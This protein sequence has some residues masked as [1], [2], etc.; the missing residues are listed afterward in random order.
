VTGH[1]LDDREVEIRVQVGSR[2]FTSPYRLYQ[3]WGPSNGY[4]GSFLGSKAAEAWM[5]PLTPNYCRGQENVYLYIHPPVR[6]H[7]KV[8]TLPFSNLWYNSMWC[9]NVT[10]RL[11]ISPAISLLSY[12]ASWLKYWHFWLVFERFPIQV[13]AGTP[14]VLTA[15]S[16]FTDLGQY[17]FLRRPNLLLIDYPATRRSTLWNINSAVN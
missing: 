13:S 10:T 4:W 2:I 8:T 16:G 6:P 1:R 5:W 7:G 17:V 9:T 11:K 3:L 14:I 15:F 12:R